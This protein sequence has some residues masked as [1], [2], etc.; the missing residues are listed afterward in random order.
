MPTIFDNIKTK[1]LD[2][3]I[4]SFNTSFRSDFCIGY[5]NLRGWKDLSKYIDNYDENN[6]GCCR[7]LVGMNQVENDLLKKMYQLEENLLDNATANSILKRKAT[8]FRNQLLIGYPT[9][10]EELAL[11]QLKEHL[12]K[13]K[14]K[15]KLYL[16]ENLHAKLYLFYKNAKFNDKIGYVGS[17]N[18]T[19]SGLKGQGELNVDVVDSDATE[20]L[21]QWFN[22]RWNDRF[23]L[24][25]SEILIEILDESWATD[26]EIPPYYIYLKMAYHLASEAREGLVEFKIPKTFEESLL[27]F[28]KKAVKIA[29]HHLNVRGGVMIGDVVGLGKTM[30]AT[31]IAKMF[32]DD[33]DTVPL[34]ICPKNLESMWREY[35]ETY[36]LRHKIIPISMVKK[37]LPNLR[38]YKLVLIDESHNLRNREGIAYQTIQNYIYENDSKVILLTAT[39]YNK[40]YL[41]L[42]NQLRLFLPADKDIGI[43]PETLLEGMTEIKFHKKYQIKATTLEAF[44]KSEHPDDWRELMRLYLIRRT[45]SFVKNNYSK[46]DEFTNRKYLEF[47]DGSRSYFPDRIPRNII[48]NDKQEDDCYSKL[49]TVDVVEKITKL[50]LPRYILGD[51]LKEDLVPDKK[52][53]K[54]IEN[55]EL[56]GRLNKGGNFIGFCKSNLFKRLESS[57]ASFLKSLYR[58]ILR[59][60]IYIYALENK[61]E[62]PLGSQD[63]GL[64]DTFYN[65]NDNSYIDEDGNFDELKLFSDKDFSLETI[66]DLATKVYT[67][68][69]MNHKDKFTWLPYDYFK[70]SLKMRLNKDIENLFDILNSNSK[71]DSKKDSKLLALYNLIEK[72]HKEE[73]VLIFTQFADTAVY[74]EKELKNMGVEKIVAVTGDSNNPTEF[75]QRFS[76]KSNKKSFSK[77]DELRVLVATDVLSEGQNLQDAHIVVNFDL[78]WAIIRLIQRAGRVDRIGQKATE[79]LCYSF[80][81]SEGIE[82]VLKLRERVKLRLSENAEVVGTDEIFF[83]DTEH[84]HIKDIYSEKAGILD[85]EETEEVDLGSYAYQI[86]KNAIDANPKL[87]H[88]ISR[89]SDIS[90]S[91]KKSNGIDK[92]VLVYTRTAIGND[93]LLWLNEKGEIITKSQYKILKLAECNIKEPIEEKILEHHNVVKR[94]LKIVAKE[95]RNLAGSLGARNSIRFK[96]YERLKDY[97]DSLGIQLMLDMDK[98]LLE[99]TIDDIYRYPLTNS[100]KEILSS[101][102][103]AKISDKDLANLVITLREKNKLCHKDEQDFEKE[104]T[105]ICSMG[106]K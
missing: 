19:F 67:E 81:P 60:S 64:F 57:G 72:T 91:T 29:A 106:I 55:L 83:E 85:E 94:G 15:V 24:D 21:S 34:I 39:P 76:P 73:K 84:K 99:K 101:Q 10:E 38:R 51:L 47:S 58:H 48:F 13:G 42:S 79:I 95:E 100:S 90:Y 52:Y 3:L 12:I 33:F 18:L 11:R 25:I 32:D 53:K 56:V 80:L 88:E 66:R 71:W 50:H 65:D 22:D 7:I 45:R 41:D 2:G 104:P 70:K 30:M 82:K 93:I 26:R 62:I 89:L 77:E 59:D 4:D 54:I 61:L 9:N 20:K 49:Y 5:F 31:A 28:Q 37:E 44:E 78:P 97:Y 16:K 74:L 23:C 75:A 40:T 102:I 69:E 8:E 87:E 105:I 63:S 98:G 35:C 43:R 27:E 96:L 1:L 6:G 103:K 68:Y 46:I 92:G 17:S 86:W 36:E 14:V